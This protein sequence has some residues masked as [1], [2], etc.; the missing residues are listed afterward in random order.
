MDVE[1]T[2]NSDIHIILWLAIKL[3]VV[4]DKNYTLQLGCFDKFTLYWI[5]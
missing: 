4:P 5:L 2:P 3:L 1:G